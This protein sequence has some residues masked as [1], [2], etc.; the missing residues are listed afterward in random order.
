MNTGTSKQSEEF[1]FRRIAEPI[2]L[3]GQD[4][5]GALW[6]FVLI[7]VLLIGFVYVGVMYLRDSRGVGIAWAGVLGALRTSVYLVI[8]FIF[9]LPSRQT[10]EESSQSSRVL[11]LFDV[12]Q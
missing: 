5:P 4:V 7:A 11:V 12:S 6:V 10:V 8:A 9:L 1:L 3:F 2:S